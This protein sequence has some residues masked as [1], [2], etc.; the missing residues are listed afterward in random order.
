MFPLLSC[1]IKL[2][3]VPWSLRKFL[4]CSE[5]WAWKLYHN[6]SGIW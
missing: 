4:S 6:R 2:R 3:L 5:Y 1:D